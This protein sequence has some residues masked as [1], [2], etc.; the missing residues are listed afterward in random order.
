MRRILRLYYCYDVS[1]VSTLHVNE[2]SIIKQLY[3]LHSDGEQCATVGVLDELLNCRDGINDIEYFT[4]D[5]ITLISD[6]L[7]TN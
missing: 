1:F 4:Y 5:E 7:C 2:Q 3:K 6:E